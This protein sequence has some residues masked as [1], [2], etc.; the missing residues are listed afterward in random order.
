M[1]N[2]E[3]EE[4]MMRY[5]ARNYVAAT[6]AVLMLSTGAAMAAGPTFTTAAPNNGADVIDMKGYLADFNGSEVKDLLSA[7]TVTVYQYED[8]WSGDDVARASTYLTDN[9]QSI[10][11]LREALK[12][13]KPAVELL[14]QHKI[15]VDNV[16]DII[17]DGSG[18]ISLYVQ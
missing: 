5:T 13:D 17:T 4:F 10:G 8:A 7:K 12:A 14:A 18:N 9:F 15:G 11:L 1:A 3:N 2:N 6:L 16:V